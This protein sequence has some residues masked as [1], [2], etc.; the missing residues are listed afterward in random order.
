M[1][2]QSVLVNFSNGATGTHNMTGG[3]AEPLRTVRVIGTKG[4]LYG[5]FENKFI[6]VKIINPDPG[7]DCD[8]EHID[9][10]NV[11][12]EGHSGG[13]ERLTADFVSFQKGEPHSISCTSIYDS[14][15]GHEI[16]FLADKSRE[17]G[18]QVISVELD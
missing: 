3:T 6:D 8:I 18:G 9:F 7:K 2:H 4:E 12:S 14:I 13:D 15:P 11:S 10:S 5:E 17:M 16:I 1:D